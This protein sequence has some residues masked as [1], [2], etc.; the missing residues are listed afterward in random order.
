[1][2][3]GDFAHARHDAHVEHDIDAVGDLNAD[4]AEGRARGPHEK[5]DHVHRAAAHGAG[6]RFSPSLS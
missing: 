1:M 2:I 4:F 6:E 3:E 5:R